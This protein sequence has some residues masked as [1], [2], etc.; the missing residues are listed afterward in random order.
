VRV[1][2]YVSQQCGNYCASE[3]DRSDVPSGFAHRISQGQAPQH[4]CLFGFAS[5]S[6]VFEHNSCKQKMDCLFYKSV[7]EVKG[8]T[9]R[10]T[11]VMLQEV[12]R[13]TFLRPLQKMVLEVALHHCQPTVASQAQLQQR[14]EFPHG[15]VCRLSRQALGNIA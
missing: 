9:F 3:C 13:P 1:N 15:G 12:L 5:Y 2:L 14:Q 11:S 4:L 6:A 7:R 10:P 8:N